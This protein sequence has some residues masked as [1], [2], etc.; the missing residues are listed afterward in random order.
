MMVG[1]AASVEGL[2]K[3]HL[4]GLHAKAST[5]GCRPLNEQAVGGQGVAVRA[6]VKSVKPARKGWKTSSKHAV[7]GQT[8]LGIFA[9]QTVLDGRVDRQYREGARKPS[10]QCVHSTHSQS[11]GGSEDGGWEELFQVS[12]PR[13]QGVKLKNNWDVVLNDVRYLDW[14]ARQDLYAIKA[15]HDKVSEHFINC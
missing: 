6:L 12:D 13:E 4:S 8:S 2:T 10:V 11:Q 14:R 9:G 5:T 3:G 1:A 7:V 15:A